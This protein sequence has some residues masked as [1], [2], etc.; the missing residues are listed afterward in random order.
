MSTRFS[1][2]EYSVSTPHLHL[3]I[4]LL[5]GL[6][7][8]FVAYTNLERAPKN[9]PVFETDENGNPVVAKGEKYCRLPALSR[10]RTGICGAKFSQ[11]ATFRNHVEKTHGASQDGIPR[12]CVLRDEFS[13]LDAF[14]REL[15]KYED[16]EGK[17]DGSGD[18][19]QDSNTA[20]STDPLKRK[21][22]FSSSAAPLIS[23][24]D[25]EDDEEYLPVKGESQALESRRSSRG[26]SKSPNSTTAHPVIAMPREKSVELGDSEDVRAGNQTKTPKNKRPRQAQHRVTPS[27][28][29]N[30][31][32]DQ[33]EDRDQEHEDEE[34]LEFDLE[35]IRIKGEIQQLQTRLQETQLRRKLAAIKR[36]RTVR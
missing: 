15:M 1:F 7:P 28:T 27:T 34:D 12:G 32:D 17:E 24:S 36:Q 6:Q 31:I 35:E 4:V 18:D 9:A 5:R 13:T 11:P 3:K 23:F 30:T 22:P 21:R 16:Y 33:K 29:T 14:Y 8:A 26:P 19:L 20:S 10:R 2:E 25:D